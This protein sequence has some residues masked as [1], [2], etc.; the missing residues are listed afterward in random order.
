MKVAVVSLAYNSRTFLTS[1]PSYFSSLKDEDYVRAGFNL[2]DSQRT[3][4]PENPGLELRTEAEYQNLL[5]D[6]LSDLGQIVPSSN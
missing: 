4:D 6:D 5:A 2:V 3:T 1:W